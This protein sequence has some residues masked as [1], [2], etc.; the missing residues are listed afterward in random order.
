L[1]GSSHVTYSDAGAVGRP[2]GRVG[3][4]SLWYSGR[5]AAVSCF[6]LV[7]RSIHDK[8]QKLYGG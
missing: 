1:C 2:G 6:R 8:V 5:H 3:P 7:L 4:Q